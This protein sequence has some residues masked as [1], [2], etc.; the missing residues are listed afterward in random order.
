MAYHTSGDAKSITQHQD[1]DVL[2]K[3]YIDKQAMLKVARNFES[4]FPEIE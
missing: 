2:E 3:Y 4:F 1:S